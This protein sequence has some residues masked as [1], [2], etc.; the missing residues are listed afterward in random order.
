MILIPEGPS[1]H[2]Q[3]GGDLRYNV[4]MSAL[5]PSDALPTRLPLEQIVDFCHCWKI[6]RLEIFGSA[7]RSDF[8]PGSDIDFL[9]TL[10]ADA[11]WGWEF[12]QAAEEL[13][14][15]IGR[16]VDLVSRRAMERSRNPLRKREILA[17]ARVVYDA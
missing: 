5:I 11:R 10:A 8:G 13:A 14:R 4:F 7:L 12:S 2:F 15:I 1:E 17:T 6:A 16:P 3:S 9:Y